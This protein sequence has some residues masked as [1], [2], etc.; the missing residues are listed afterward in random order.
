MAGKFDRIYLSLILGDFNC[1]TKIDFATML[2][3]YKE[4][5]R[6]VNYELE[7]VIYAKL[8]PPTIKST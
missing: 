5:Y 4:I 8:S 6:D 3:G 2:N 1:D 7:H